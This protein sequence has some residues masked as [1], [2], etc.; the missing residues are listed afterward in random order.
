MVD[1]IQWA[2]KVHHPSMNM[3]GLYFRLG[4]YD[5]ASLCV[6]EAIKISQNKNDHDGIL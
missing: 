5:Q 3:G 4:Q 2:L 1:F 6:I